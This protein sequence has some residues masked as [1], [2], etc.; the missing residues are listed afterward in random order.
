MDIAYV[1]VS[2]DGQNTDRQ[3]LKMKEL[4][5][6]DRYVFIDKLSGKDFNREQYQVMK[7]MLREG[8][9]LYLDS[10]DRLGR[11]YDGILREYREIT[12]EV[13]ADIICLDQP[14]LFNSTKYKEMGEIGKLMEDQILSLLAYVA[15]TERLKILTRQ[16]AGIEIAKKAGK[17]KGR[18]PIAMPTNFEAVYKRWK[19]E[20]LTARKAM[21]VLGLKSNTFYRMVQK[22]ECKE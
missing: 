14:D 6:D 20:E 10:L 15:E 16:R 9:T 22:Y 17:Y 8:D 19:A 21:E 13:G 1:R 3:L 11:N 4:G 12:R 5:I 2:S 18:K 7:R